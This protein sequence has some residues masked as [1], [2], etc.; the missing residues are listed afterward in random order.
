MDSFGSGGLLSV[1]LVH[2]QRAYLTDTGGLLFTKAT[3]PWSALASH[4]ITVAAY[5]AIVRGRMSGWC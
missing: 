3:C 2:M 4:W 1:D 5:C